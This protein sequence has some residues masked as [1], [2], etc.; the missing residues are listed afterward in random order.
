MCGILGA[1][2]V[3]RRALR[4]DEGAFSRALDTLAHRGPDDSG[5]WRSDDRRV[6]LGHRRLSII[7]LSP[8]GHQPMSN[9]DGS[10][11]I[12]FNG[13]IYNFAELREDLIARGHLFRS[14]SDTETIIH[15]Y[16][17]YGAAIVER[18]R[19]MF[20]FAIYDLP[21]G[22]ILLARDR[23]GIKP[24]Y[25]TTA[26]GVLSF[27][28]EVKALLALPEVPKRLDAE[29]LREYL[30]FGKVMAPATMFE[31]IRK[32]HAGHTM[33]VDA[34][35]TVTTRAY[36]SPYDA[37]IDAPVDAGEE[38]YRA[39]LL[40]LL[41]ES[42]RLR[43]VSDVPV[44][45]FLSGGVDST[46]NLAIMSRLAGG[47]VSTFTAGFKG[48]EAYDERAI[49][50]RAA[51]HYHADHHEIEITR[52]DLARHLPELAWYL[53]EPVSDPTV[54]PIYFLSQ[55]ARRKGAVVILNGDGSDEILCGYSKY[56]KYLRVHRYWQ[57]VRNVPA[58]ILRVAHRV[59]S[60][61]G[62]DGVP[63]ELLA[64][65]A[66]GHELYVGGTSAL[67][68]VRG[69]RDVVDGGARS[70]YAGVSDERARF[71]SM[72]SSDDYAE[73]LSY[74]G[75]RSEVEP[76]F[77]YRADRM[78]MASSVEIRVPFLDHRLVEFAMQMPQHLKYRDGTAKYLLKKALEPIVPHEF[79]YRRK[80]GFCVPVR[81]WAGPMMID[82]IR[83]TLP[84]IAAH[85]GESGRAML[86]GVEEVLAA[87]GDLESG[88]VTWEL[89]SLVTWYRRWFRTHS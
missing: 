58:P 67:K 53:D 10:V 69:F 26:G 33:L 38:Y 61:F 17:E 73:W 31:G 62:L 39:K 80:Q 65:A 21:R 60:R 70:V 30:A 16:E 88:G 23:V 64:R 89:Y 45:V 24:L 13:E 66:G 47:G 77:L 36:W 75:M 7:D 3:D 20:A 41:E 57:A 18:L 50:R 81:E 55:L 15:G 37:A 79:L 63:G 59:G 29:A 12:T 87:E 74:W 28:S 9:E 14:H 76:V 5:V 2:S 52:E 71:D 49:A 68:S 78:G 11:W 54:I 6:A 51:E 8:A 42:V 46:A 34:D 82:E 43:M 32:L 86:G 22:R 56:L 27:A 25:Y 48:Q 72:R 19:G 85:L 40:E 4:F 1:V 83:E 35:G 84:S 44:G